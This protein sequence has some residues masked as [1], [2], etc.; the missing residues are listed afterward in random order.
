M[1]FTLKQIHDRCHEVADCL[2]WAQSCTPNGYP[3]IAGGYAHIL[4]WQ[5]VHG[6]VPA[7]I[8]VRRTCDEKRCCNVGH[9]VLM[10]RRQQNRM[11]AKRGAWSSPGRKAAVALAK[12][13]RSKLDQADV[14][15][16]RASTDTGRA[17]ALRYGVS[18]SLISCIRLGKV[19]RST[20][21]QASI[22]SGAL[23]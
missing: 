5:I 1:T 7:G 10:T 20:T 13:A 4:A 6:P 12:R 11:A 2:L 18:D 22:F 21:Q 23:T 8:M 9:M 15:H 19:W 17:L 3:R 14:D 16:I